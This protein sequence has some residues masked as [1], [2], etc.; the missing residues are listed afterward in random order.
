ME[1]REF[2]KTTIATTVAAGP[3]LQRALGKSPL[4]KRPYKDG[5]ALS[6]IGFGG[7]VVVG[8][9]QPVANK[10]VANAVEVGINYFD[11][12]PSYG[13]GEAEE[14][15]G[16][17]LEPFRKSAFLACKTQERKAE[18]AQRELEQSLRRMRTDHFDLYQFHAVS[19]MDDVEQILGPGGAAE[20]FVKARKEGKVRYLGFSAHNAEAAIALMDRMPLDSILFPVNFVNYAQGN[21][22]P[23]ILAHAKKKGLARLALKAMAYRPWPAGQPREQR[24]FPKCWYEPTGEPGMAKSGIRFTLSEDVTAAIPPGDHRLFEMAV[25]YA[26]QFQPMTMPERNQLLASTAGVSPIF[27]A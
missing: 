26:Q 3:L 12:A 24:S 27:R 15:L 11:V 19:S 25:E 9:E 6:I 21:F 8:Q 5:I 18:G 22:G 14:K 4:A 2:V 10:T 13:R 16:P 20:V 17:A 7:I 23:Q 1:R